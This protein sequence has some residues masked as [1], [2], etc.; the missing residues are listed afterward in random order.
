MAITGLYGS[1]AGRITGSG[2]GAGPGAIEEVRRYFARPPRAEA[3]VVAVA[4][5]GVVA[6]VL[7]PHGGG[8]AHLWVGLALIFWSAASMLWLGVVRPAELAIRD[9]VGEPG[10]ATSAGRSLAREGRRLVLSSAATDVIFALAFGL[11]IFQPG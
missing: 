3:A 7:D 2:A 10:S 8:F 1:M 4:P 9:A 5:L 6:L 11:M